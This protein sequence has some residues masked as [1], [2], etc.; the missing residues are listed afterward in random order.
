MSLAIQ[1]AICRILFF[2]EDHLRYIVKALF[3]MYICTAMQKPQMNYTAN[4]QFIM[5]DAIIGEL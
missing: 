1:R 2:S 3:S 4:N 5:L